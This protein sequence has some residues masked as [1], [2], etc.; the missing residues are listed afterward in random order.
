MIEAMLTIHAYTAICVWVGI[1]AALIASGWIRHLHDTCW[2][3]KAIFKA[4]GAM[5]MVLIGTVILALCWPIPFGIYYADKIT[6]G[7]W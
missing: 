2:T 5:L 6:N 4:H 7:G 3:W 1:V